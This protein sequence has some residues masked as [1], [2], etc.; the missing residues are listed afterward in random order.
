MFNLYFITAFRRF[1]VLIASPLSQNQRHKDN[2][3]SDNNYRFG[4]KSSSR[5]GLDNQK[6]L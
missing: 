2:Y 5:L 4:L 1:C 6:F 3:Q